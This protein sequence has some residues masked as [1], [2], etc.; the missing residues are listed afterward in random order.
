MVL[1]LFGAQ[2]RIVELS[3]ERPVVDL[4]TCTGEPVEHLES[5]DPQLIGYL[6]TAQGLSDRTDGRREPK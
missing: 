4:R 6:R 5:G 3:S 1:T 2:W